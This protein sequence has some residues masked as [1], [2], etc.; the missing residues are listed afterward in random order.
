MKKIW[1]LVLALAL[2]VG[3]A[4]AEDLCMD[5]FGRSTEWNVE[6]LSASYE[7]NYD[8]YYDPAFSFDL[9]DW[10]WSSERISHGQYLAEM[11]EYW[12][13]VSNELVDT[14]ANGSPNFPLGYQMMCWLDFS[15]ITD[16]RLYDLALMSGE[17]YDASEVR[18]CLMQSEVYGWG[19]EDG[20]PDICDEYYRLRVAF[21][22]GYWED[23]VVRMYGEKDGGESIEV[24]IC[25]NAPRPGTYY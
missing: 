10:W 14:C 23:M 3:S 11:D 1:I 6:S 17:E 4:F 13:R 21:A 15:Y 20:N 5:A 24:Q 7:G 16:A 9:A 18:L 12:Y 8:L 25:S 2:C 19:G 22:N